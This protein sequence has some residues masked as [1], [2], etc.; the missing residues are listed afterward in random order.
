MDN[1]NGGYRSNTANI[2]RIITGYYE[3]FYANIYI[4]KFRW[5][6]NP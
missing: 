2:K 3:D 6:K 4:Y 5:N 1:E